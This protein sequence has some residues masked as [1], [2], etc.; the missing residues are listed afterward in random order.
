[1]TAPL[2]RL[3]VVT[4]ERLDA[5]VSNLVNTSGTATSTAVATKAGTST[6]GSTTGVTTATASTIMGRDANGRS[7][8]AD[9]AVAADIAT[10]GWV[11]TQLG[12]YLATSTKGAASGVAS[13]DGSS[14]LTTA[15]VPQYLAR[16]LGSSTSFP[17]SPRQGDLAWRSDVG[18]NGSLWIY[19][20]NG[21]RCAQAERLAFT[22][23][24]ARDAF[25]GAY[26]GLRC[27][28]RST[29][30]STAYG[31]FLY[32][33]GFGWLAV[34]SWNYVVNNATYSFNLTSAYGNLPGMTQISTTVPGGMTLE[35][36]CQLPSVQ[37]SPNSRGF[38]QLYI[39]N[40]TVV[41]GAW[42]ENETSWLI[43]TNSHLAGA[44]TNNSTTAS[45]VAF[46]V[47]QQLVAGSVLVST[48]TGPNNG[49]A[50]AP[51]VW[52]WRLI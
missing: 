6:G 14:F 31:E 44:F 36:E 3:R 45:A 37:I 23:Q 17:A 52:R 9:P 10:M 39:G 16:N 48:G 51:V 40:N 21:W 12:S 50:I 35:I 29:S 41:S 27:V 34:N 25:T 15:Q 22:D 42:Y 4:P 28:V 33:S 32:S 8:V 5:L 30:S 24:S 26:D 1:M 38:T 11:N 2:T 47:A 43:S 20:T 13:L 46:S 18:V 49:T 19:T 7:Q